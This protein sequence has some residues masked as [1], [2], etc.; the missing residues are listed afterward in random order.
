RGV[1]TALLNQAAKI[2]L[3]KGCSQFRFISA[4]RP[5]ATIDFF[6]KRG[7]VD[8]TIRDNWHVFRIDRD[9][10]VKLVEDVAAKLNPVSS[11]L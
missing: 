4:E 10:L 11:Q 5:Q 6:R 2:T 9:P 8:V 3:E 7:A 1:G